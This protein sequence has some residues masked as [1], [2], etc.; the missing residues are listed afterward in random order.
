[1]AVVKGIATT[2]HKGEV[3]FGKHRKRK[4]KKKTT[5]ETKEQLLHGHRYLIMYIFVDLHLRRHLSAHWGRS[6]P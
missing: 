4:K 1:M 6:T 3:I 5:Q 2:K